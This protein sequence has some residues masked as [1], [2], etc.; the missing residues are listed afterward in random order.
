MLLSPLTLTQCEHAVYIWATPYFTTSFFDLTFMPFNP[1]NKS[2]PVEITG[3]GGFTVTN[4]TFL[5]DYPVNT[6][7]TLNVT[8]S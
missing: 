7:I 4:Y 8:V 3:A 2:L 6:Q 1:A 5:V